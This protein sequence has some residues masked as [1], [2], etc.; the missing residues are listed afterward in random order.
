MKKIIRLFIAI[1]LSNGCVA[2]QKPEDFTYTYNDKAL[3]YDNNSRKEFISAQIVICS[4]GTKIIKTKDFIEI[5]ESN[6]I[7]IL[8]YKKDGTTEVSYPCLSK[9]IT[10]TPK[11]TLTML[12]NFDGTYIVDSSPRNNNLIKTNTES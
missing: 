8:Q 11:A 6:G 1:I 10:I 5:T 9:H 12:S 4:D 3:V 2:C 7:K